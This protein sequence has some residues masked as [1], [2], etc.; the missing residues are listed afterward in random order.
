LNG[1]QVVAGSN[2]VIP[3]IN[4]PGLPG[5]FVPMLRE[6]DYKDTWEVIVGKTISKSN[7]IRSVCEVNAKNNTD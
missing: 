1:V 6:Y 2:P 3:T 5:F 4:F 7:V